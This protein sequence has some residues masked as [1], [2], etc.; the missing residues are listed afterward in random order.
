VPK[1]TKNGQKFEYKQVGYVVARVCGLCAITH[2]LAYTYAIEQ[3]LGLELNKKIQYLHTLMLELDR[4]H[5]HMLCLSHTVE[6]AGFEAMFM[7]IM[8]DC[9]AIMQLQEAISGNQI[10]FY[11]KHRWGQS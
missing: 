2:S 1:N 7:K 4:I 6:N 11:Y 3:L 10:Q 5:S 9:E 8:G